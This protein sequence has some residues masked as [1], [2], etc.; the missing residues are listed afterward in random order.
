LDLLKI[1]EAEPWKD[2]LSLWRVGVVPAVERGAK[3]RLAD[4]RSVVKRKI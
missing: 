4:G 2:I 1:E 3:N